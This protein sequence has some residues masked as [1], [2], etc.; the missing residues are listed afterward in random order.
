VAPLGEA[1]TGPLLELLRTRAE[2]VADSA[3]V[4]EEVSGRARRQL[5]RWLH[6]RT[7]LPVGQL[8]YQADPRAAA[9]LLRK[10]EDVPWDR[11]S[12]PMSLRDVEP[13]VLL[14]LRRDDPTWASAPAWDFS[15]PPAMSPAG[16]A[17]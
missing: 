17:P 14:Q 16:G 7:T 11:W 15:P 8:G 2:L 3:P 13:D 10:P 6:K 9:G 12:A 5:D 1:A 4:S